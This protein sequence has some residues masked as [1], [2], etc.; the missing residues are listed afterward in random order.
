MAVSHK[1]LCTLEIMQF[2]RNSRAKG[3][4]ALC[5]YINVYQMNLF[6]YPLGNTYIA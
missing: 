4:L 1:E 3:H 6:L 5:T 2:I